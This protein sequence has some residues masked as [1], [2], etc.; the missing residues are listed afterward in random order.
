MGVVDHPAQAVDIADDVVVEIGLDPPA[1]RLGIGGDDAAPI[2]TLFLA[3]IDR[4]NQRRGK[5]HL[6]QDARGFDDHRNARPIVIGAR[7]VVGGIQDYGIDGVDVAGDDDDSVGI[8][9]PTLDGHDVLDSVGDG[10]LGAVKVSDGLTI[11]RQPPQF[12][13]MAA[14]RPSAQRRAAPMPRVSD[15]VSDLVCRVPN[16]TRVVMVDLSSASCTWAMI[17]CS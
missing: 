16:E 14:N 8:G 2:E 17:A 10:S 12:L 9:G 6:R 7:G 1:L 13:E 4:E 5:G 11:T 3:G 15:L